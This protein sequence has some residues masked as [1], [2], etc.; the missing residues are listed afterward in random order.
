[1][2]I[3]VVI[4]VRARKS[5]SSHGDTREL[6]GF[7][8]LEAFQQQ[9]Q[10]STIKQPTT[11]FRLL[12]SFPEYKKGI[13]SLF[14]TPQLNKVLETYSSQIVHLT[15][16]RMNLPLGRNEFR[17]YERIPNLRNLRIIVLVAKWEPTR[18]KMVLQ[19]VALPPQQKYNSKLSKSY[20]INSWPHITRVSS[21]NFEQTTNN[22]HS[23]KRMLEFQ[24]WHE[25]IPWGDLN[26]SISPLLLFTALEVTHTA[27]CIMVTCTLEY[28][29]TRFLH[30]L[31]AFRFWT[32]ILAWHHTHIS[33]IQL[34][35]F[36]YQKLIKYSRVHDS[37]ESYDTWHLVLQTSKYWH[38]H[39]IWKT[40]SLM[41]DGG[42]MNR[43]ESF[44]GSLLGIVVTRSNLRWRECCASFGSWV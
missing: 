3:F 38:W 34:T 21:H 18:I 42:I 43:P 19:L 35:R 8:S 39:K 31:S 22:F 20:Q 40:F 44:S 13:D 6:R 30:A 2:T 26:V 5:A 29:F 28:I 24:P 15:M 7:Q 17:F 33:M 9:D 23:S 14:R 37:Q 11:R 32:K 12:N 16:W 41:T 27:K 25:A 36:C 4:R 10:S 1:M